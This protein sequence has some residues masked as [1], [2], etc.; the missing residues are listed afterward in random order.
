MY[1]TTPILKPPPISTITCDTGITACYHASCHNDHVLTLSLRLHGG[2]DGLRTAVL[3]PSAAEE[4]SDSVLSVG[5][6]PLEV[7]GLG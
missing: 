1:L 3:L 4:L 6:G 5:E 7:W 2:G